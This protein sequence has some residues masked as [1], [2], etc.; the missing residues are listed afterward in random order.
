[1]G[2]PNWETEGISNV[3]LALIDH[4]WEKPLEKEN[5]RSTR[6]HGRWENCGEKAMAKDGSHAPKPIVYQGHPWVVSQF[7]EKGVIPFNA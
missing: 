6:S 5:P 1:M 7:G 3:L 2:S 4:R